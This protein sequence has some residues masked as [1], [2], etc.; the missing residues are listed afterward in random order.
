[1]AERVSAAAVFFFEPPAAAAASAA[2]TAAPPAAAT[3]ALFSH[4]SRKSPQG[5]I[6]ALA[7]RREIGPWSS[8]AARTAA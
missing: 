1:M 7:N 8:V 3:A 4:P 5:P 2:G 6:P